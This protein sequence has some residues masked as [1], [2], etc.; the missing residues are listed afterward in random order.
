MGQPIHLPVRQQILQLKTEGKSNSAI[1]E[2]TGL[3][4]W[5]VRKLV[6]RQRKGGHSGL[7]PDYSR[8]GR[9]GVFRSDA[10]LRR[11]ACWLKR[12]HPD[13]GAPFI[14]MKLGQRYADAAIPSA[15]QMQRWFRNTGLNSPRPKK[16]EEKKGGQKTGAR[17]QRP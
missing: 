17:Q 5:T 6:R 1:A 10:L 4:F 14:G 15:R 16:E 11:A 8:C 9:R 7:A 13:W 12:L 3:S 2:T